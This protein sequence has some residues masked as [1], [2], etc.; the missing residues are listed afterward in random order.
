M[1]VVEGKSARGNLHKALLLPI[2]NEPKRIEL[3]L[4]WCEV[5]VQATV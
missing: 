3:E 4:L 1:S 5:N 2:K